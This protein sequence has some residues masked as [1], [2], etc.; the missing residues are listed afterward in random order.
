MTRFPFGTDAK[1]EIDE[2][3]RLDVDTTFAV[4]TDPENIIV[5]D[6]LKTITT[7]QGV[8]W[9]APTATEDVNESLN[10]GFTRTR[11]A[12]LQA[13]LKSALENDPRLTSVSV[14]LTLQN[15]DL[16]IRIEATASEQAIVLVLVSREDGTLS[17]E[18]LTT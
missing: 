7:G 1:L 14:L 16:L 13:T 5:W 6:M 3:G 11:I 18:E 8:L 12:E 2:D 9:W 10:D 17:I 15:R 4:E